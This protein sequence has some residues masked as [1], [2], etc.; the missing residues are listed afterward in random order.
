MM[1]G[2]RGPAA[3]AMPLATPPATAPAAPIPQARRNPRRVTFPVIASLI[4]ITFPLDFV[5]SRRRKRTCP[6]TD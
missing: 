5:A 3:R 2:L 4:L 1:L 6:K